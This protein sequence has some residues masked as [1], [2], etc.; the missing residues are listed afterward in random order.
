MDDYGQKYI[1][2]RKEI[3]PR[4]I[5]LFKVENKVKNAKMWLIIVGVFTI[6]LALFYYIFRYDQQNLLATGVDSFIGLIFIGL[7]F[8]VNKKPYMAV[9]SGL[10]LYLSLIVIAAVSDP[11]TITAGWL[12]R[13]IIIVALVS[14]LKAAKQ[15]EELR[16]ELGLLDIDKDK[17]IPIDL[18]K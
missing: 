9:L 4:E 18:I 7:A 5:L 2:S 16:R 10:I 1:D 11:A 15:A 17:E 6:G 8:W 13:I 3:D 12:F 14:G